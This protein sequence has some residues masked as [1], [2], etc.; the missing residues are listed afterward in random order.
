MS[1]FTGRPTVTIVALIVIG[2]GCCGPIAIPT[3]RNLRHETSQ[4]FFANFF[5]VFTCIVKGNEPTWS[6]PQARWIFFLFNLMEQLSRN[7]IVT[8]NNLK[9]TIKKKKAG[10]QINNEKHRKKENFTVALQLKPVRSIHAETLL[11][12]L[13]RHMRAE[14]NQA[15]IIVMFDRCRIFG[16]ERV[17]KYMPG[18][19]Q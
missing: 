18:R 13:S 3:G 8:T 10:F 4:R 15:S 9:R 11:P 16:V 12:W 7:D 6:V 1:N 19:N 5:I 2:G 17:S 14:V